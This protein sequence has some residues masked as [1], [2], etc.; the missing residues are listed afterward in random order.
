MAKGVAEYF[1]HTKRGLKLS[2][3][4]LA[5]AM[6]GVKAAPDEVVHKVAAL[7]GGA[8]GDGACAEGSTSSGGR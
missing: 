3:E 4:A 7:Q 1:D 8:V 5:P 6:C 2:A